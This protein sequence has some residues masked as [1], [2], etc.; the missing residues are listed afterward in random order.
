MT[1]LNINKQIDLDDLILQAYSR[2]LLNVKINQ[3]EK[4]IIVLSVKGKDYI[5]NYPE[6]LHKIKNFTNHLNESN[7][8]INELII[9]TEN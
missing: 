5:D 1:K 6:V 9:G 2:K 3:L 8:F 7:N 4:K